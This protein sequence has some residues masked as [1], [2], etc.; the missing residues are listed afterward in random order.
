M[1]SD[2]DN[3]NPFPLCLVAPED[4]PAIELADV[5][6]YLRAR[7]LLGSAP[8]AAE[9]EAIGMARVLLAVDEDFRL[10]LAD[11]DGSVHPGD[12]FKDVLPG[13]A[14]TLG[15]YVQV[16]DVVV[17][18][19]DGEPCAPPEVLIPG[20]D[21]VRVAYAWKSEQAG[22]AE[23]ISAA[24]HQDLTGWTG[25]GW[26]VIASAHGVPP[27]FDASPVG[28]RYHPFAMLTR[29][30]SARIVFYVVDRRS[31]K[32]PVAVAWQPV[33][34]PVL[35]DIPAGSDAWTIGAV[36]CAP[37]M[38]ADD[39]AD[40]GLTEAAIAELVEATRV[41][42]GGDFFREVSRV[43]RMPTAAGIL[44][45]APADEPTPETIGETTTIKPTTLREDLRSGMGEIKDDYAAAKE[46][47]GPA[48]RWR[49]F[50]RG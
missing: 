50:R 19:P 4:R 44:V 28:R 5:L 25:D 36:L 13:M 1:S 41:P 35:T 45:D 11:P 15:C 7:R 42:D 12:H 34:E 38:S 31:K 14:R 8:D 32:L 21:Q 9:V 27:A 33:P 40:R 3:A 20:G 37:T 6:D 18:D 17:L 10:L 23:G 46:Q 26:T 48:R 29:T 47:R 30:G 2:W 49:W 24:L 43:L 22:I 39:F 16:S